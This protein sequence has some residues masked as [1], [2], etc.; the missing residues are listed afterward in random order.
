MD[1]R[2]EGQNAVPQPDLFIEGKP[3]RSA[4]FPTV[5]TSDGLPIIDKNDDTPLAEL[6][7]NHAVMGADNSGNGF[8]PFKLL[9]HILERKRI[10]LELIKAHTVEDAE[11]HLNIIRPVDF[12]LQDSNS[13]IYLRTFALLTLLEKV[14]DIGKFIKE[15]VS[16]QKLPVRKILRN[17][18]VFLFHN[19]SPDSLSCFDKWKDFEREVFEEKQWQFLVPYFDLDKSDM[20]KHQNLESKTILPWCKTDDHLH[21]SSQPSGQQGGFGFV[22][23][24]K[25]DPS[26]HGFRNVLEKV[27]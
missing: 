8:W 19:D 4:T 23:R 15:E 12:S 11:R 21:S 10:L 26:S 18:K 1:E 25:I 3:Y 24:V 17:G 22:S 16:D 9:C 5:I 6:L 20:A 14:G 27:S 7:R 13:Q 2:P